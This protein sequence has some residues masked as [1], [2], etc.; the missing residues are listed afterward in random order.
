YVLNGNSS[1]LKISIIGSGSKDKPFV[2]DGKNFT[3]TGASY[4]KIDNNSSYI[5]IKNIKFKNVDVSLQS[6]SVIEIGKSKKSNV[7][8]VTLDNL[9][10]GYNNKGFKDRQQL[11]QFHW[12]NVWGN[13]VLIS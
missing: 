6:S 10:F 7:N 2:L 12:I 11:T 5:I 8:H 9:A 3:L 13:N 4:I 1:N